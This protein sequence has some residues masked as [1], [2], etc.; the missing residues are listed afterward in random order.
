M[1][2]NNRIFFI[3]FFV[4]ILF[5]TPGINPFLKNFISIKILIYYSFIINLQCIMLLN[6]IK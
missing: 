5:E 2:L 4:I 6:I 3:F 1:Y